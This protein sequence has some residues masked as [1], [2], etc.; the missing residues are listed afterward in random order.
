MIDLRDRPIAITGASSGIGAATAIACA[1]AG[2]PVTIAARRVDKLETLAARIRASGGRVLPLACDVTDPAQ[3]RAVVDRTVGEFGSIYAVFANA[4]YGE[5][6]SLLEMPDAD[7][8]AMFEAN[9]F[10][11]LNVVRP[12]A[13]HMLRPGRWGGGHI[14][15]C[16]SCLAR[17][18]IPFYGVYCAT[19]ASQLLVGRAMAIELEPR[20]VRVSTVHPVGTKT[21]F[22]DTAAAR[23][24]GRSPLTSHSADRFMQTPEFVASRI[25]RCLRRPRAEVWPG[26]TGKA[27]RLGMSICTAFP[28]VENFVLRRMVKTRTA[29]TAQPAPSASSR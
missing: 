18:A 17:M 5:E 13:E 20:G 6:R 2:M 7:V 11:S 24:P 21:E 26:L 1:A 28:G 9:F 22:F 16:S 10:G 19:K 4:G 8:R 27:V 14:L 15:I 29:K 12:A 25:V 23:S 3:C